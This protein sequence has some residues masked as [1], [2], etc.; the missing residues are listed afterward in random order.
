M[1]VGRYGVQV[2]VCRSG[3]AGVGVQVGRCEV[4]R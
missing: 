3:Y 4:C 1:Q 2:W